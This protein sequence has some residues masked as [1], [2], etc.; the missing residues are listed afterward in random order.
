MEMG[1]TYCKGL[2]VL[3]KLEDEFSVGRR[4]F[5]KQWLGIVKQLDSLLTSERLEP[6]V[7][8]ECIS[9]VGAWLYT[10]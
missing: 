10:N 3:Q 1:P 8:N 7:S 9:K 4:Q 5:F 2:A 6:N